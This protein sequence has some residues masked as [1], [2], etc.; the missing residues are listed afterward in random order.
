P[1][2]EGAFVEM[3]VSDLGEV[4]TDAIAYAAR[5]AL[6]LVTTDVR[7][8]AVVG[9]GGGGVRRELTRTLDGWDDGA[10]AAP[11]H[12]R[13]A[14]EL[15]AMLTQ[16]EGVPGRSTEVVFE[17]L[18][19]VELRGDDGGLLHAIET[20]YTDEGAFVVRVGPLVWAYPR[21]APPAVLRL[22]PYRAR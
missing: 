3:G 9:D 20:G 4:P 16:T 5:T 10:G 18:A 17:S 1:G 6:D 19:I 8:I 21:A 15:F 7:R 2:V 11:A 14:D 12:G 13:E 22:A